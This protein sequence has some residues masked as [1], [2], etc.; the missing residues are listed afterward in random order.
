MGQIN[1]LI[2]IGPGLHYRERHHKTLEKLSQTRPIRILLAIDLIGEKEEVLSF[3]SKQKLVPEKYLF[4]DESFRS[5][6]PLPFLDHSISS[7]IDLKEAEGV[8]IHTEPKAHKSYALWAIGQGLPLF[9]DKP[10]TAFASPQTR[11][12]LYQDYVEIKEAWKKNQVNFVIACPRRAHL[13][14]RFVKNYIASLIRETGVPITFFD[15]HFGGGK[16]AMPDEFF[17]RENHPYK[18]GYGVLL[19]SG[20]HYI[21]LFIDFLSLQESLFPLRQQELLLH[22][23]C[24]YPHQMLSLF[25]P[26]FYSRFF[27]TDRCAPYFQPESLAT[28]ESFGETEVMIMGHLQKKQA[29][30]TQFNL[31]LLDTTVSKRSWHALPKNTYLHNGRLRQE[32]LTIHMGPLS[33]IHISN[34]PIPTYVTPL[35]KREEFS[36][37]ILNNE[38]LTRRPPHLRLKRS[39]LSRLFPQLPETDWLLIQA[40]QWQLSE[41]LEGR[42]GSSP[43]LSHENTVYF[44]DL[45][46]QEIHRSRSFS[47]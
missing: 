2:V 4:L 35:D 15:L 9:S 34:L 43:F 47:S 5:S 27:K 38:D 18:Y 45:I 13:G 25:G 14:Y 29:V 37:T 21:D 19:H 12:T 8:L 33:S 32:T 46:Y 10:L 17:T 7:L 31:K 36:I 16:W 22:V 28:M 23:L 1:N 40:G 6:V 26:T 20:Y 30:V 3:F 39:D 44:L 24:T 41:F 11:D 42:D